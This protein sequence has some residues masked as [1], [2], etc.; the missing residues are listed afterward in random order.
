MSIRAQHWLALALI[1]VAAL[2]IQ[3]VIN[4]WASIVFYA[5]ASLIN[6]AVVAWRTWPERHKTEE[7]A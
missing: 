2:V 7:S 5:I 1:L 4:F 6:V 3:F